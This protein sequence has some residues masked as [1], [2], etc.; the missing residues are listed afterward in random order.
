MCRRGSRVKRLR[1]LS[2]AHANDD[3]LGQPALHGTGET[4]VQLHSVNDQH[5][6]CLVA[7]AIHPN[8]ARRDGRQF[9]ALHARANR[10]VHRLGRHSQRL[11]HLLLSLGRPTVVR[12]HRGN[13]KRLCPMIA[14]PLPYRAD[15]QGNLIN[16]AAANRNGHRATWYVQIQRI[17]LTTPPRLRRRRVDWNS[18]SDVPTAVAL[19][20]ASDEW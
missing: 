9:D 10:H 2:F 8:I 12:T 1:R 16:P 19:R 14:Q 18:V 13:H 15:D 20:S 17:E 3:H 4:G 11:D 7:V 6:V 5:A